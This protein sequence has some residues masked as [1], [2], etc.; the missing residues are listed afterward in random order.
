MANL[1]Q[2]NHQISY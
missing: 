2:I 1:R